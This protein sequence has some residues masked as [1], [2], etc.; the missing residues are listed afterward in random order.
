VRYAHVRPH[1]LLKFGSDSCSF[2]G[3]TFPADAPVA[4]PRLRPYK[5]KKRNNELSRI[6]LS[7]GGI[8]ETLLV[9]FGTNVDDLCFFGCVSVLRCVDYSVR[10]QYLSRYRN[11]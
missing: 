9:I 8:W 4:V 1:F 3:I 2:L 5:Y 10:I 11:A 6:A 7:I